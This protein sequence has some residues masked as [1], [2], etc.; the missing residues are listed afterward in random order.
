LL[1]LAIA[2]TDESV[3]LRQYRY[4]ETHAWW[5]GTL[6]PY[7]HL[8]EHRLR[9]WVPASPDR[10]WVLE[11]ELTGAQ[12]WLVGSA[13]E[14]LTEGFDPRGATPTGRFR[15]R[16]GAFDAAM[17][18]VTDDDPADEER[19][20]TCAA[21]QRPPR[22]NWQSPSMAFFA[23]LPRDP[24]EL[25]EQLRIDN[26]GSWFTP[27]AAAVTALRTGLAPAD[28]RLAL[29]RAL[30]GLP[31]VRVVEQTRNLDGRDCLALVHDAGR[32]RTEVLIDPATGQFAGERDTLRGDSRSGLPAGVVIS[33]TAVRVAVVDRPGCRPTS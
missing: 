24:A 18:A 31:H 22:G 28:L 1:E 6:G 30:T 11:R 17:D 8:A 26:P 2:A 23:R 27:F 3:S 21:L 16:H 7:Q 20:R 33:D 32:T 14:A 25:L 15:A 9:Q 12:R 19:F 4:V 5:L 29:Y 10:D 13:H